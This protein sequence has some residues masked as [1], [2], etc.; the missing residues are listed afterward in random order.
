MGMLTQRYNEDA[1]LEKLSK[2][3]VYPSERILYAVYCTMQNQSDTFFSMTSSGDVKACF[4]G[5]TDRGRLIGCQIGL[6]SETPLQIDMMLITK[7]KIKKTIFQQYRIDLEYSASRNK[8]LRFVIAPKITG[9]QFP[10]QQ[11]NC[12]RILE[13][14]KAK[15][16]LLI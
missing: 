16:A 10:N 6:M 11:M 5:L 7:L 8:R 4:L 1:M 12:E 2:L 9:A 3:L 15:E 14:L 13:E